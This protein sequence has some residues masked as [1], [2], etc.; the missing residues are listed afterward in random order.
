MTKRYVWWSNRLESPDE[1][2]ISN[3]EP[4]WD[5]DRMNTESLA[6]VWYAHHKTVEMLIGQTLPKG[7]RL[8]M[9]FDVS[10]ILI[11]HVDN[12]LTNLIR[13]WEGR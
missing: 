8:V 5:G 6:T 13:G 3:L 11:G 12:R 10:Q 2:T 7:S 1:V 9:T 4:H